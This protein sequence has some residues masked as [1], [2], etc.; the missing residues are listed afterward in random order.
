M[1]VRNT[2]TGVRRLMGLMLAV[3]LVLSLTA[4]DGASRVS[5]NMKQDGT[6]TIAYRLEA[7]NEALATLGKLMDE[8]KTEEVREGAAILLEELEH[9]GYEA[10]NALDQQVQR[11]TGGAQCSSWEMAAEY[12]N[13][14]AVVAAT[15][16]TFRAW[17]P[18]YGGCH[19]SVENIPDGFYETGLQAMEGVDGLTAVID[20]KFYKPMQQNVGSNEGVTLSGEYLTLDLCELIRNN[21]SH[22]L[23]FDSVWTPDADADFLDL[24]EES[25][26]Y[27]AAVWAKEKGLFYGMVTPYFEASL[28]VTYQELAY[29]LCVAQE[30]IDPAER[31]DP[32]VLTTAVYLIE[33]TDWLPALDAAVRTYY[34]TNRQEGIAAVIRMLGIEL[35]RDKLDA[36]TFPDMDEVEAQYLDDIKTAYALGLV[37]GLDAEGTFNPDGY[38][39]RGD[40][41]NVLYR[42]TGWA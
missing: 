31:N 32:Q 39:Y 29:T 10:V 1:N 5:V 20:F 22:A 9:E 41:A 16:I 13:E 2:K 4:C 14:F 23:Y 19:L 33:N 40:L 3:I 21:D 24:T 12:L 26:L 11:V 15:G 35:D 37:K 18:E 27:D 36:V 42:S 8:G 38:L 6:A 25:Y 30:D 7:T 34:P 28:P 17:Q